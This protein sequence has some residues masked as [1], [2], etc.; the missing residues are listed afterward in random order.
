MA[1]ITGLLIDPLTYSSTVIRF[2][3]EL[4]EFYRLLDTQLIGGFSAE[5]DRLSYTYSDEVAGDATDVV[6]RAEWAYP[7]RGKI[8]VTALAV[9]GQTTSLSADQIDLCRETHFVGFLLPTGGWTA[10]RL[11]YNR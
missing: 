11:K 1:R 3:P 8:L 2:E 10:F 9:N 4:E 6:Y 7:L 5:D